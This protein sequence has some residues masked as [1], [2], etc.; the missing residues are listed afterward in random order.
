MLPAEIKVRPKWEPQGQFRAGISCPVSIPPPFDGE[1]FRMY[2]VRFKSWAHRE[3][4]RDGDQYLY[5]V[6]GNGPT[7]S[8]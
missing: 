6:Y 4:G 2:R 1:P 5:R 3:R 7:L 8:D